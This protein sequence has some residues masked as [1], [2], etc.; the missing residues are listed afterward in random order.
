M[1]PRLALV[2]ALSAGLPVFAA[3]QD[4]VSPLGTRFGSETVELERL[5]GSQLRGLR[6]VHPLG[7][8]LVFEGASFSIELD[9]EQLLVRVSSKR[10]ERVRAGDELALSWEFDGLPQE[11][12][13][14]FDFSEE[15]GWVFG[16]ARAERF[17]LGGEAFFLVDADLD[18]ELGVLHGD[19]WSSVAGGP[20]MPLAREFVLGTRRVLLA[21][22]TAGGQL[23]ARVQ[24]VA[25]T[26]AQLEAL[27]ELN[28]LRNS[29]GLLGVDLA[30]EL[31]EGCT[32]HARYLVAN[33]WDGEEQV[34][35]QEPGHPS[36]T[37]AGRYAAEHG[38]MTAAPGPEAVRTMWDDP[39]G[40]SS[41]MAPELGRVGISAAI[42]GATVV[43]ASSRETERPDP[44]LRWQEVM[45]APCDRGR[46]PRADRRP[47]LFAR[48]AGAGALSEGRVRLVRVDG[49]E[50]QEVPLVPVEGLESLRCTAARPE[51]SLK[52]GALYRVEHS[53]QL[54]GVPRSASATFEVE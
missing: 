37:R 24:S 15:E 10:V 7:E 13:L 32:E 42:D 33:D 48:F 31:S 22:V 26:P 23:E 8:S 14:R 11:R 44:T 38:Y 46:V 2:L 3:L 43:D 27:R 16:S 19:G 51:R 54:S 49:R 29:V 17:E 52:R 1:R 35:E 6:P 36:G 47:L 20:L 45:L 34:R 40:R 50:P 9:D 41:L 5:C 25:G 12:S 28:R 18:G 53:A 21:G 39:R 30:P 4:G